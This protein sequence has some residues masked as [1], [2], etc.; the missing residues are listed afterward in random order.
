M[1]RH[2]HPE[3]TNFV[4]GV[5]QYDPDEMAAYYR[6][7]ADPVELKKNRLSEEVEEAIKKEDFATAASI[8]EELA[9]ICRGQGKER[10]AYLLDVG[11]YE[12]RQKAK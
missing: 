12:L 6:R 2:T 3:P 9:H 11:A 7:Q 8:K 1:V 10:D 4:Y 5:P